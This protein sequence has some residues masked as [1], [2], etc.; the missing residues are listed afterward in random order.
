M[1]IILMKVSNLNS[2]NQTKTKLTLILVFVQKPYLSFKNKQI[3][4]IFQ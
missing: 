2:K 4:W 1:K 3:E